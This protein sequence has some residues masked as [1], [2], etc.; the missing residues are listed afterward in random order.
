MFFRKHAKTSGRFETRPVLLRKSLG[1]P[2]KL[3]QSDR[4]NVG[5]CTACVWRESP[6]EYGTNVRVCRVRYDAFFETPNRINSLS[7]KESFDD[8]VGRWLFFC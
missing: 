7:V 5:N 8:F 1:F 3:R 4:F 2:D 6:T